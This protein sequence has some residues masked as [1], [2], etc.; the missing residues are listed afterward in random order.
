MRCEMVMCLFFIIH[1]HVKYNN[2]C[3]LQEFRAAIVTFTNG[4]DP[5]FPDSSYEIEL[6]VPLPAGFTIIGDCGVT[7]IE[8]T[9]FDY[10]S[11]YMSSVTFA[12]NEARDD[13]E[14]FSKKSDG[15]M[16]TVSLKTKQTF[17]IENPLTVILNAY[18]SLFHAHT[19]SPLKHI[20]LEILCKS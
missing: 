17:R 19:L 15:K 1:L 12:L 4:Y 7:T 2:H 9:D 11:Q 16:W 14:V 5:V 6:T 13:L 20:I 10:N 18:V 3:V 8:A